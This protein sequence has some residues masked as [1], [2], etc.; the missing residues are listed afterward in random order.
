MIHRHARYA[1]V[2][3]E[4]IRGRREIGDQARLLI[5]GVLVKNRSDR[6]GER[7][8]CCRSLEI[9]LP[10]IRKRRDHALVQSRRENVVDGLPEQSRWRVPGSLVPE[11][12]ARSAARTDGRG[13]RRLR[14][15]PPSISSSVYYLRTV[16]GDPENL[17]LGGDA[18]VVGGDGADLR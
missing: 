4:I 12:A 3:R 8:I 11:A 2:L 6:W 14:C 17:F 15:V 9:E 18:N 7:L 10:E 16:N 5:H 13:F 1:G